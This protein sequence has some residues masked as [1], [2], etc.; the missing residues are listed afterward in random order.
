[1]FLWLGPNAYSGWNRANAALIV[2]N[3]GGSPGAG[4]FNV[5]LQAGSYTPIRV[6]FAQAQG[7]AIFRLSVISPDGSTLLDSSTL[8]SPYVLRYS[9]D[10]TSAPVFPEFGEES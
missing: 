3:T 8:G 2:G 5:Q 6:M 1:M 9:C 4:S 10:D 7:E